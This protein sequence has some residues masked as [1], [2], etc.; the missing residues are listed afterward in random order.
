MWTKVSINGQWIS[1]D[2]TLGQGGIGAAHLT[3]VETN[4]K[5]AGIDAFLPVL[6]VIGKLELEIVEVE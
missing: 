2:A 6:N 1:I 3:L 5:D 4:F